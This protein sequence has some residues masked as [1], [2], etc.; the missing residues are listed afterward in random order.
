[1]SVVYVREVGAVIR[2]EG[3]QLRVTQQQRELFTI[4]L[5]QLEQLVLVGP[6]QITTQAA[7]KLMREGVDVVFIS[8]SG[9]YLGRLGLNNSKFA[10]LRHQ[11]LRLCDDENRALKIAQAIV[12]AKIH[13]QRL[14]LQRRG[15]PGQWAAFLG[16]MADMQEQALA[17]TNLDQLRGYEGKGAAYYFEALRHVF[18]PDWGFQTRQYYPP[19]DPANA[20]LSF[21]YTLLLRDVEAKLQ[22]VGLD[23]YLGFFHALG[24]NRPGL[25]LD[26]MEEFRPIIAD[27]LVLN[28]VR[29]GALSLRDFQTSPDPK[30]PVRLK[31]GALGIL[32]Q[33]YEDRMAQTAFHPMANGQTSYRRILELQARQLARVIMGEESQYLPLAM[34]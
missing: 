8:S 20:L 6:V 19:P 27:A 1:M 13:H 23:S 15:D 9:A 24:Y 26:M 29:E 16:P 14:I 18:P 10:Q 11:Q 34:R 12:A 5:A 30:L 31:E 22:V 28:L 7:V 4:P 25:A 2:K 33:A 3:E 32:I 21:V 17:A